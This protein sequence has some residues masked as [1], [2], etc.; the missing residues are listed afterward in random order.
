MNGSIFVTHSCLPPRPP[1]NYTSF[2]IPEPTSSIV[3]RLFLA[4][5]ILITGFLGNC[6]VIRAICRIPG[7]KPFVYVLVQNVALGELGHVLIS[8]STLLYEVHDDWILGRFLCKVLN[9]IVMLMVTNIT[10]TLAAIAVYRFVKLVRPAVSQGKLSSIKTKLLVASFWSVGLAVAIPS[11][12][13][14]DTVLNYDGKTRCRECW[15][16]LSRRRPYQLATEIIIFVVPF[17]VMV[18]SYVLVGLKLGHH[19]AISSRQSGQV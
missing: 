17:C 6:V 11:V 1:A 3:A 16:P 14:R 8:P 2:Y 10:V 15:N 5:V 18:V 9:P 4:S 13:V 7:R 19:M 12:V